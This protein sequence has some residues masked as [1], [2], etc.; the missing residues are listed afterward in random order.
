MVGVG[1]SQS[2][3][4]SICIVKYHDGVE[5][6]GVIPLRVRCRR[7]VASRICQVLEAKVAGLFGPATW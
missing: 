6:T 7:L 5:L 2:H 3:G 4:I 1:L